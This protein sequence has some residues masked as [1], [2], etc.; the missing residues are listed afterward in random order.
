[1]RMA[2]VATLRAS[3]SVWR[4]QRARGGHRGARAA[5]D[6]DDAVVGLDQVSRAGEQERAS[7]VGDD[8]HR[9]EAAQHAVRPPIAHEL[10]GGPLELSLMLG[11]LVLEAREQGEGVGGAAGEPGQDASLREPADLAR[12]AP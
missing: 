6:A 5:A 10:D 3:R 7:S 4:E 8:E 1:M 12:F 11:E 2:S 9:L